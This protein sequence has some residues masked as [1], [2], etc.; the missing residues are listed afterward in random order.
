MIGKWVG[1]YEFDDVRV[2]LL[3]ASFRSGYTISIDK[4]DGKF[5][6]GSVVDDANTSIMHEVG[7]IE[8]SLKGEKVFFDKRMPITYKLDPKGNYIRENKPHPTI[9]YQ[10]TL[11]KYQMMI[12]GSWFFKRK[13]VLI[14][15]FIPFLFRPGKGIWEMKL[16]N[17]GISSQ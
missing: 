2:Q 13:L 10:G 5:F 11:D 9:Y 8:G 7:K 6:S 15:G 3:T 14:F 4:F 17:S 16:E 12:K 1:W